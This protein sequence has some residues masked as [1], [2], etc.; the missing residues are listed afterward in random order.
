MSIDLEKRRARIKAWRQKNLEEIK[1]KDR[2]RAAKRRES[3]AYKQWLESSRQMRKDLKTKYRR[4]K[5]AR[6]MNVISAAASERRMAKE[7]RRINRPGSADFVGPLKPGYWMGDAAYYAWRCK[8]DPLYYAKELDRAQ[9]YKVRTRHG[10]KGSVI[11]WQQMPADVIKSKHL[12]YLISKSL[13][14][15]NGNEKH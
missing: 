9:R 11:E 5:G 3:D 4:E 14:R 15:S 1:R 10:Y 7:A 8:S 6:P 12:V 2:E 13:K